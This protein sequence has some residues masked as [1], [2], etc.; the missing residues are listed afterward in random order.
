M[1]I[2]QA[3][4]I[5]RSGRGG[6]G[7]VSFRREKYIP[8]G[9]PD[10]GDG[11]DGGSVYL[12]A[13]PGTDTLMDMAGRHHWFAE[14]GKPGAKKQ[15]IGKGGDD[16]IIKLPPGTLV[17]DDQTGDLLADM[18]QPRKTIC[19]AKGGKGGYGNERFK[20]ATNQTP[21]EA[22]P[23]E[24]AVEKQL[25]LE[26]KLIADVG[27]IGKPNAGKSTLL[28]AVSRARPKIAGYAFTTLEPNLGIVE[29][30]GHR[31]LVVA[32]IPGL[33]EGAHQGAGLGMRFLRHI[34][35]TR[36]LLHLV[37]WE[38]DDGSDPIDNIKVIRREL[39]EHS[40]TLAD[41]PELLAIS[42]AEL[43]GSAEDQQ[44]VAD[45]V[46][47]A[48]GMRP[49]VFSSATGQGL[50]EMLTACYRVVARLDDSE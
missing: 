48:T 9:G 6:D 30:D 13:E 49:M 27:L 11:G 5:V 36:V 23:G 31:R 40:Q 10:G 47:Q 21:R 45:M 41:K 19:I 33:I 24:P 26:L 18:D 8:K 43:L 7:A 22:T 29:L 46:E 15:Q 39:A 2:D 14:D 34:E 42:K 25:R 12:V 4:I 20:S 37:E 32:D 3:T 50:E 1:F 38:P 28:A 44:A 16:L 35:R 17:Y